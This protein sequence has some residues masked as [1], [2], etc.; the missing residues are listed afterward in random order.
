MNPLER[1]ETSAG[2]RHTGLQV[3]QAAER[4]R[5]NGAAAGG[6]GA[7]LLRCCVLVAALPFPA[8]LVIGAQS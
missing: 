2:Q 1:T 8:L 7:Y 6:V 5:P 4:D 3:N